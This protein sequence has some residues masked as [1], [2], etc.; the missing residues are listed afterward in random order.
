MQ[1][2]SAFFQTLHDETDPTGYLGRGTHYSVLRAVVFHDP[3]GRPVS[4]GHFADFAVIWD[5]DHDLRVMEPVEE[6]YHRGL[7]SSFLMF[8]EHKGSFTAI[9][10]NEVSSFSE[11]I[12]F[13]P[14]FLKKVDEL[15]LSQ[16]AY[17]CLKNENVVYV[18]DLVQKFESEMLRIPSFGRKALNEVKEALLQMGLH[19]G[20]EE[21]PGWPPE[22]IDELVRLGI[23]RNNMGHNNMGLLSKEVN[24]ICQSLHDPW[25]SNVLALGTG[26]NP[27]IQDENEK[28]SL[29]LKNLMM[30]WELGIATSQRQ[31]HA[32]SASNVIRHMNQSKQAAI[33]A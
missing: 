17:F 24:A 15:Q 27:I 5:E 32:M 31:K 30:L 16:R 33:E 22:N 9:V 7:L 4:K 20:T 25:T 23:L 3:M 14:L 21:V 10:S 28:V 11:R 8:G 6:I 1:R 19:L 26:N 2:Y 12:P 13:N 18:G 29:Y